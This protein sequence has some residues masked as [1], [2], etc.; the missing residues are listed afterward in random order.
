MVDLATDVD[1]G[2]VREEGVPFV[3]RVVNEIR[4][5]D[6]PF[7]AGSVAYQ[8]FVSLVPLLVLVFFAVSLVGDEDLAAQ[9]VEFSGGFL[10]PEAAQLLGKSIAG[11]TGST[12][13]SLIGLVT[14]VW[15]TLKVFRGLDTAFSAIYGTSEQNSFVDQ[16]VD[17]L[18]MLVAIGGAIL[19]GGI[20]ITVISLLPLPGDSVLVPLVLIGALV[21]AFYPMYA[22]FP[23][24]DVT[25]REVLPGVLVAALG[26]AALQSV[27]GYYVEFA[28]GSAGAGIFGAI[29]LLLTW[30]YFGALVLLLGAVVNAVL[31][32]RRG[33][34]PLAEDRAADEP[35]ADEGT[36]SE[37]GED[38][39]ERLHVERDRRRQAERE[40]DRLQRELE[41]LRDRAESGPPELRARNHLLRQRLRWREKPL[42]VRVVLR[43]FGVTPPAP[44]PASPESAG[45][46]G[47]GGAGT[48]A[49]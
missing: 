41:R 40:R 47:R 32:G 9:V 43:L 36:A 5:E 8:A 11:K 17:G 12:G 28:G 1:P 15:G 6:V 13:A 39:A 21:V 7:M 38:H 44:E 14:L 33:D 10:P 27:F 30:L 29:I 19:A 46:A 45:E 37:R 35:P 42:P 22:R 2:A 23:D 31:A 49:D 26:W 24:V 3:R 48:D 34:A 25:R 20:A 16:V 18:V 4:E